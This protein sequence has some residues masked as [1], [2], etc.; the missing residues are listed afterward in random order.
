MTLTLPMMASD[1][2]DLQRRL[3]DAPGAVTD[4]L[5]A[6]TG[7]RLIA[8]VVCQCPVTAA[9]DNDLGVTAGMAM[10]HRTAVLRGFTTHRPYVYAESIFVPN[11]L[12]EQASQQLA[13]TADPIG[14]VLVAHGVGLVR[15]PLPRAEVPGM[16]GP[17]TVIDLGSEIVWSRAYRLMIDGLPAFA[18]REWFLRSVLDALDQQART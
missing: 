7:E 1:P 16:Y 14:R 6:L 11:R 9:V 3:I 5:E 10:T 17:T 4:F 8:E 13:G 12:P 15:K 18:I 2:S